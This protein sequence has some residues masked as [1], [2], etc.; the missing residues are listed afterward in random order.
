MFAYKIKMWQI[1]R[2]V[3][4]N[5]MQISQMQKTNSVSFRYDNQWFFDATDASKQ[6][7]I[8]KLQSGALWLGCPWMHH[9]YDTV[10]LLETKAAEKIWA[11]FIEKAEPI[12]GCLEA[13]LRPWRNSG[14]GEGFC[15]R[16]HPLPGPDR[17]WTAVRDTGPCGW[18]RSSWDRGWC[19]E[20]WEKSWSRT[21]SFWP[22]NK[23]SGWARW[24]CCQQT[25]KQK[26]LVGSVQ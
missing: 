16:A 24:N 12:E 10:Y 14:V 9:G 22:H 25:C 7:G 26:E 3:K 18:R 2:L 8:L 1:V 4:T 15:E 20:A 23:S 13:Q 6:Q 17:R 19:R 5:Q 11:S 21:R